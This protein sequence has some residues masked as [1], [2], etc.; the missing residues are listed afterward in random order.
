MHT[1]STIVS[2]SAVQSE[3]RDDG[4][5]GESQVAAA[6]RS[7]RG[8]RQGGPSFYIHT[9]HMCIAATDRSM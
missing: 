8:A 5:P 6:G 1:A 4:L 9:V 7:K 3:E 2:M